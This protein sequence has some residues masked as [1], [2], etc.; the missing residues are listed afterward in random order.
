MLLHCLWHEAAKV[1]CHLHGC[2]HVACMDVIS[3]HAS[4]LLRPCS[5][6]LNNAVDSM[7]ACTMPCTDDVRPWGRSS[8]CKHKCKVLT[9]LFN[10]APLQ[11]SMLLGIC[12]DGVHSRAFPS[13]S[14]SRA[15]VSTCMHVGRGTLAGCMAPAIRHAVLHPGAMPHVRRGCAAGTP[16][17]GGVRSGTAAAGSCRKL[18]GTAAGTTAA[19]APTARKWTAGA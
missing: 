12:I 11:Q 9:K 1:M 6:Q 4:M 8:D 16:G 10:A 7:D 17:P 19:R 5:H 14:H 18:G 13:W 3:M 2:H 15:C